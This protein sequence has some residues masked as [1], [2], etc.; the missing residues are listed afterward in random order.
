MHASP[1]RPSSPA[2][3]E[4]LRFG[5]FLRERQLITDEQWLAAL[6]AHWSDR[7]RR[8]GQTL[9][10]QGVLSIE[11]IEAEARTYHDDLSVVE[12]DIRAPVVEVGE[13]RTRT[14]VNT[15]PMRWP[16]A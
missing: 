15:N 3:L 12:L 6:A 13:E 8:I 10:A 4:P 5:E 16:M 1:P 7:G 2:L 11:V 9:V 14:G